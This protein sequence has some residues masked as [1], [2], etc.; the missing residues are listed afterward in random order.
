MSDD[1]FGKWWPCLKKHQKRLTAWLPHARRIRQG[2]NGRNLRYFTL[3]ARPMID[4]YLMVREGLVPFDAERRRIEGVTFCECEESVVSE[5]KELIGVEEAGFFAKLEDL[6]LFTDSDETRALP[7]IEDLSRYLAEQ[8][9]GLDD[10]M[11]KQMHDKRKH[12]EFQQLFPFDFINLDFCDRYYQKPPNVLRIHE[13][14]KKMLEWQTRDRAGNSGQTIH[15]DK[16]VAAITCRTDSATPADALA[17]L[18]A[19]VEQNSRDHPEYRSAMG[20]LN[21]QSLDQWQVADE[22]DFFMSA[23]PK[24]I[25]RLAAEFHWDI[26][27][28]EHL[29][30]DRVNDAGEPYKM[31]CL[32]VE[33]TRAV[34]CSTYLTAVTMALR[35]DSRREIPAVDLDST[36]GKKLL[37]DLGK[38]VALRNE[39]ARYY[40]RRELPDPKSEI[41]RL[42]AAGVPV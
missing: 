9:E 16:F 41:L 20:R 18:K 3:C 29:Y 27:I 26:E 14:V 34:K 19:I 35:P 42:R 11:A 7:T 28:K 40:R 39:Q 13:T 33:F 10:A 6:V 25:A 22:L 36:P 1:P 23:W 37:V 38:I 24:E 17:R 21:G 2:V 8:G 15:V 5:M 30:Y 4:V 12:L 31:V 32:V